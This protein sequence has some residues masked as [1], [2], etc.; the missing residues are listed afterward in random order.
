MAKQRIDY[1][2][3]DRLDIQETLVAGGTNIDIATL[4]SSTDEKAKVSSNDTTP[5]FLNGKL[6]AGT[7]VTLTENNNGGNETLTISA[8]VP[9]TSVNTQTGAVTLTAANVGAAATSHTHAASDVTSGVFATARLASSGTASASTF[10]RG[11]QTWA[12][13]AGGVTGFTPSQNT[14]SPN[15]T[16]N[17]SRLLAD[18]ATTNADIVLQP[19]GTGAII[20]T[21]PDSTVNGGNKR[22]TWAV[23]LQLYR[24]AA[25]EVASG[26]ASVVVGGASNRA[27][28]AQS[29]IGAGAQNRVSTTNSLVVGG[30]NNVI[31]SNESIVI[32]GGEN[33]TATGFRSFIG[34]GFNNNASGTGAVIIG[35]AANQASNS[36]A[37]VLGGFTNNVTGSGATAVGGWFN[38]AFGDLSIVS[39]HYAT[40]LYPRQRSW[41][42]GRFANSGDCQLVEYIARNQTTDATQV[43]L[44]TDGSSSEITIPDNCAALFEIMLTAVQTN[45]Q[46]FC[47]WKINGTLYNWESIN[48]SSLSDVVYTKFGN[49]GGNTN[50][51]VVIS[52]YNG[53]P[54]TIGRFAIR[55]TGE[56]GKTIR[57]GAHVKIMHV[58]R[59]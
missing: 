54:N 58:G 1:L 43:W 17:A 19:K 6:V 4:G 7:N 14:S 55:V 50:W 45:A 40:A 30:M 47:G 18:A 15:N 46:E 22:G 21:L 31:S 16:V 10:L 38:S 59:A 13:V 3:V 24:G 5:G 25:D 29:F 8:T 28:G 49:T 53:S 12:T 51:G 34:S 36:Y 2:K 48:D 33:N 26:V 37:S 9:V 32:C 44:Y 52:N 42:T 39:G 41:A 35:G 23:D 56:V 27:S 20:G 57:W 11:D